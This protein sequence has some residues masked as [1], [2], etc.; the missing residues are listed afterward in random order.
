MSNAHAI[1]AATATLRHLLLGPVQERVAGLSDLAVTTQ[2]LDLVRK[3]DAKP[4]QI[5]AFLYQTVINP[6]WRNMDMPRQARPGE[7]ALPPLALNLHYLITAYARGDN[8]SDATASSHHVIG[9]AM[10]VLHDHAL[11]GRQEI[12]DALAGADLGDQFERIRITPLPLALEDLSKLW[13]AFQTQYRFSVAYEFAVVLIDSGNPARSALPVLRRGPED[14]GPVA[15]PGTGSTL[16]AV[17]YPR[18]QVAARL[19]EDVV[20][21]G[22]QLAVEN[23]VVRFTSLRT[24]EPTDPAHPVE[25]RLTIEVIPEL[26]TEVGELAVHI[27]DDSNAVSRWAPGF[28][29]VA[30]IVTRPDSLTFP[31]N[32]LAVAIAPR[33]EITAKTITAH[34]PQPGPPLW[35]VKIEIGCTPNINIALHQRVLLLFGNRQAAPGT[36]TPPAL[37][38][39]PTKVAFLLKDVSAGTHLVRL[40]VDG[41]DSIP[42]VYAGDPLTPQ[43]DLAQQVSVP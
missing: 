30:L 24:V 11:L 10:S 37:P 23:T 7:V 17:R 16:K 12:R 13:A 34:S 40:R 21:I 15:L 6:A 26:G 9:G 39:D 19:G 3:G 4:A 22:D 42:V 14:R 27:P 31:T 29:S 18:A 2:P 41:V 1:A 25:A 35:D 33:I 32:E 20:I 36:L 28:Y 5:N 38:G 8:D 43:F